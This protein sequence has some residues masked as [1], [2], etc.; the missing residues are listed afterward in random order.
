MDASDG[1]AFAAFLAVALGVAVL[2]LVW[3]RTG[4][5]HAVAV[6]GGWAVLGAS[7]LIYSAALGAEVGPAVAATAFC[8]A[9]IAAVGSGFEI[10]AAK[11]RAA[12][13][14]FI[15]PAET[16][17]NVWHAILRTVT[18][19][20]LSLVAALAIGV[21]FTACAPE[22]T[23]NTV[24]FGV[25]ATLVIWAG[26]AVWAVTDTHLLRTA[27]V[28]VVVAASAYGLALSPGVCG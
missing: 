5:W 22:T 13:V 1:L 7:V 19:G 27:A 17:S 23:P 8:I 10:R 16:R 2:R 21:A 4:R 15:D 24:V 26:L 28:L 18:T 11:S 6:G 12:R 25:F 20:V 14:S 9:G 3:R